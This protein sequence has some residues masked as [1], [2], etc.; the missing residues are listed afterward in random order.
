MESSVWHQSSEGAGGDSSVARRIG[1]WKHSGLAK[2]HP[3]PTLPL[4]GG[5][6]GLVVQRLAKRIHGGLI[7]RPSLDRDEPAQAPGLCPGC[8]PRVDLRERRTECTHAL[9][10]EPPAAGSHGEAS[11]RVSLEPTLHLRTWPIAPGVAEGLCVVH[12]G[13]GGLVAGRG[14]GEAGGLA[15]PADQELKGGARR[16]RGLRRAW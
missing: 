6:G 2:S 9:S 5:G 1:A 10:P 11:R 12:R 13:L 16:P 3:H 4:K 7:R 14:V 8:G 15:V